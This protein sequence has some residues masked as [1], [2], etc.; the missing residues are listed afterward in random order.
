MLFS[1][2]KVISYTARNF[3]RNVINAFSDLNGWSLFPLLF[4]SKSILQFMRNDGSIRTSTLLT[5]DLSYLSFL[6]SEAIQYLLA[7]IFH[8]AVIGIGVIQANHSTVL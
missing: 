7:P 8:P 1:D 2:L 3:A 4:S 5:R 6:L